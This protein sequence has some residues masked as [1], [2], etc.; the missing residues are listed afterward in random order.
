MFIQHFPPSSNWIHYNY[1]IPGA[2]RPKQPK[3]QHKHADTED[4]TVN[5]NN[6]N[7]N[8]VHDEEHS[9]DDSIQE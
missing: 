5:K 2:K 4:P 8:M 7:P 1:K 6:R 3:R 9:E